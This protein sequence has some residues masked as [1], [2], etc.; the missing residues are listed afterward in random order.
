MNNDEI[1]I[2]N[3]N[4]LADTNNDNSFLVSKDVFG[5]SLPDTL[6]KSITSIPIETLN[7]NLAQFVKHVSRGLLSISSEIKEYQLDEVEVKL[8]ISADGQI[9][10]IGSVGAGCTGGVTLKFKH[11][12]DENE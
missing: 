2:V 8:E 5:E 10:L 9:G 11:V 12:M 7:N 4:H 6:K 3:Y 1:M